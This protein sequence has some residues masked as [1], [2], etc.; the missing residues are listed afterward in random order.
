MPVFIA[1]DW[2]SEEVKERVIAAQARCDF[3]MMDMSGGV[4]EITK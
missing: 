4:D 1:S 2:L 3:Y